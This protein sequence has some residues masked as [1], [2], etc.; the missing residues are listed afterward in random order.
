MNQFIMIMGVA[1]IAFFT[2][3]LIL[4]TFGC[5]KAAAPHDERER[6]A[7]DEAQMEACARSNAKHRARR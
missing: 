6:I 3:G 5:A 4:F 1:A 2:A 7:D